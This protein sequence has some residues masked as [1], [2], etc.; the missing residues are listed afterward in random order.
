MHTSSLSLSSV[1]RYF[2]AQ[3]AIICTFCKLL[4]T[5][6]TVHYCVLY[7][8]YTTVTVPAVHYCVLYL[9]YT[10]V[11]CTCCILLC[12]VPAV[13]PVQDK[14]CESE[15]EGLQGVKSDSSPSLHSPDSASLAGVLDLQPTTV[16]SNRI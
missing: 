6:S 7:L 14:S 15:G 11:Y 5:V 2:T 12:T 9:L 4:C 16:K 10:T 8:L 3:C 13:H 1:H